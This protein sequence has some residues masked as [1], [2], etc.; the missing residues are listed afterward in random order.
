MKTHERQWLFLGGWSVNND[1][2][3]TYNSPN[4]VAGMVYKIG[5]G[6][7]IMLFV[8]SNQTFEIYE[9]K[10]NVKHKYS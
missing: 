10:N 8:M 5:T 7:I 1:P 9:L 2:Q 3:T 6:K 4:S